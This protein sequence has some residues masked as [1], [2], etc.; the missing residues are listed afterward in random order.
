MTKSFALLRTNVGLTTNI[1]I[2]IQS[3]KKLFMD[4]IESHPDL[5]N[6]RFKKKQIVSTS[7]WQFC[8]PFFYTNSTGRVNREIAYHISD[9]G[10][11]KSMSSDFSKQYDNFYNQGARNILE[12]KYYTE[13]FE[14]FAP[15]HIK[16][17]SIPTNFFI[18]RIDGPGVI[19]L[20]KDNFRSEIL[21]KM[22]VVAN[23]DLTKSSPLGEFLDKNINK[24]TNFPNTPLYIDF[25]RNELSAWYGIDYNSGGYI[26]SKE[27]LE[28]FFKTEQLYSGMDKY[29][30]DSW[31][32]KGI[33]YPYI[34][35]LN[36]LFDDTPATPT[37][38]R[39]WSINRYLGF[40]FDEMNLYEQ[41]SPNPVT[42][43]ESD[44]F[45][46]KN[47]ILKS[48]SGKIPFSN[49]DNLTNFPYIEVEGIRYK[50]IECPCEEQTV[51]NQ[52]TQQS[53]SVASDANITKI[54][55]CYKIISDK[56]L[57]GK[58]LKSETKKPGVIK[59]EH[60]DGLN[61]LLYTNGDIYTIK[62]YDLYDMWLIKIGEE[63]HRIIKDENTGGIII[64][65][66]YAFEIT[67][68]KL[69]YY[70][71]QSDP[72][73]TKTI[74]FDTTGQ[75]A[76][77]LLQIYY[78]KFTDIKDFDTDIIET[79]FAKFEYEKKGVVSQSEESKFFMKNL[80]SGTI[81]PEDHDLSFGNT[82]VYIPASS[83]YTGNLETF[84]IFN[85][86][87]NQPYLS[88][89]IP[90]QQSQ[91]TNLNLGV[92]WSKN[93]KYCKWGFQGSNSQGDTPYYLN[94][95]VSADDYNRNPNTEI[96]FPSRVEK[97]LD[98]FY[99]INS[100][101][102]DYVYHSL[103]I[104]KYNSGI[105]DESLEF[106][107][108]KYLGV[109]YSQDYFSYFFGGTTE[110]ESGNVRK[111][112]EKW[113]YFNNSNLEGFESCN[114]LFKGIK[115]QYFDNQ[116]FSPTGRQNP[117]NDKL[118]GYKFSILLSDNNYDI[119]SSG[120]VENKQNILVW[121]QITEWDK[122]FDYATGSLVRWN[123]IIYKND[124]SI[125]SG[126]W[127]NPIVS[128]FK[129]WS[130]NN[131][132]YS[133]LSTN[134]LSGF[135]ITPSVVYNSNEYWYHDGIQNLTFT[136]WNPGNT[137]S[138]FLNFATINTNNTVICNGDVYYSLTQSNTQKPDPQSRNWQRETWNSFLV[139]N[140]RLS[141]PHTHWKKVPL[142][143][144][145]NSVYPL[146]QFVVH[147]NVLYYAI[148]NSN[149]A[150]NQQNTQFPSIQLNNLMTWKWIHSFDP[151]PRISYGATILDND[152]INVGG[153]LMKLKEK[154]DPS[155]EEIFGRIYDKLDDGINIYINH[156]WKNVLINIYSNDGLFESGIKGANREILYQIP[157][158]KFSAK[159]FM[160]YINTPYSTPGG[161][162]GES[163]LS[164]PY[165]FMNNLKY[166]II[167]EDSSI[168]VY[169]SKDITNFLQAPG[170]LK[171][172]SPDEFGVFK[173]S[174]KITP[175]NLSS[176][177][178]KANKSLNSGV[179]ISLKD[180]N[181]YSDVPYAYLVERKQVL[182]PQNIVYTTSNNSVFFS[183]R[184]HSGSY[185]PIFRKIDLF[186]QDS[187]TQSYN[188]YK[189][190]TE[191]TEFGMTG[192]RIVSKINRTSNI[193]KLANNTSLNS[194]Y[195]MLDETPY[196]VTKSFIFKSTW[197]LEYFQECVLPNNDTFLPTQN[198][199]Q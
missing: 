23:Y 79:N 2:T 161:F 61:K 40:Y 63:F 165:G 11:N 72:K 123:E 144:F 132:F 180:L 188:N 4:S 98:Y 101:A 24:E 22:K 35:N 156:K 8:I 139:R 107:L 96:L 175:Y 146:G 10:D 106:E 93:P 189:F 21:N 100:D 111:N 129:I 48:K 162:G 127:Q 179:L 36:F 126:N 73:F 133:P 196:G 157:S 199:E 32:N 85:N 178:L 69:K 167:N 66:D 191:L 143:S 104:E 46:D 19:K 9:A 34:F 121:E 74:Q 155:Q 47:N 59:L 76:P 160:N 151:D 147:S 45:I 42:E 88:G 148:K 52:K 67:G 65:S 164:K 41:L 163:A 95:S 51:T 58:S 29:F 194:I 64:L 182:N 25:K 190:D 130:E 168:K 138:L 131:I 171:A 56:N 5:S 77:L 37:G 149:R 1:K 39:K 170:F 53:S 122:S 103:H 153:G 6:A 7:F 192:E 174:L 118:S 120:I 18:F 134:N 30:L 141:Q 78:A 70:I 27:S 112:I 187:L 193:L 128:G 57:E 75:T 145:Q 15:I 140:S 84:M 113:S 102:T 169:D 20:T 99:T 109:S 105:R 166:C 62:D 50:V 135:G 60:T 181:Y 16:K 54:K 158:S 110:F 186:K 136:F 33:V 90:Q 116:R 184:R 14:Y 119:N 197:D 86:T 159:N 17:G 177:I 183:M 43:V 80:N 114:T 89:T 71:N 150:P 154:L 82:N 185:C 83:H 26:S 137:Y 92:L 94:N 81:P 117:L 97:S 173:Q 115:F 3:D 68:N 198:I 152:I 142:F 87:Q 44:V 125:V 49:P 31:K 55:K 91:I 124:S 13:E 195:P 176:N 28:Q 38:L 172:Y 12:N 108:D